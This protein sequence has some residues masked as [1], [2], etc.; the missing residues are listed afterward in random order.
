MRAESGPY[1]AGE[2]VQSCNGTLLCGSPDTRFSAI[3]TDS[4]DIR[5]GDLF[6][7][8]VGLNFD[9]ND[10]IVPALEAGAHGSLTDRDTHREIYTFHTKKVLIQVQ[11][12]LQAIS[13]LASTRRLTYPV[14][15]VAVTGSSGKTTVKE[16]IAACLERTHR[17]L[18][19]QGNLN[20]TIGLPM[21]VLNLGPQHTA[22]VVEAG[23]NTVGEMA[24]LARAARP[25]VSVITTI[26][27]VHLEGLKTQENVAAEKFELVRVL[28][29]NGIAV[30]PS[31]DPY[32]KPFMAGSP[33]RVVTFGVES[34]DF[35]ATDVHVAGETRFRMI[36]PVGDEMITLPIPGRHNIA[37]ALAAAAAS[38]ALGAKLSDVEKALHEFRPLAWR[39][40]M[41]PLQANR[42]LIRDCYN[43]NPQSVGAALELLAARGDG[44]NLA[45]LG[46]M[47]ELGTSSEA[48]HEEIGRQAARLGIARLVFVG[49]FGQAVER[50]FISAGG[51]ARSLT[52]A[53]DKETAW[54]AILAD[55]GKFN[56]ILVKGSRKMQMEVLAD[57]IMERN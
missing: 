8:I 10:F 15:L 33:C 6:V 32:L 4:R 28:D 7:P 45:L 42:T 11:D 50:G 2:I 5:E 36:T 3:S 18:V 52:L 53:P 43:A 46:D 29:S 37:N 9:G 23:I 26:G 48:L 16:M 27:P 30:V 12:T 55:I 13:D 40:E 47:M 54:K 17:L 25:N 38:L 35:R 57:R 41:L 21:T 49:S 24:Y 39:T 44:P 14:P 1:I 31:G 34:G 22:A 20:N 56:T 19:S 51:D